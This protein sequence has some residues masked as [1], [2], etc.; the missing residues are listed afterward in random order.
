MF[1][2]TDIA[3]SVGSPL[4]V[5][6]QLVGGFFLNTKSIAKGLVW[7]QYLSWFQY[8]FDLLVVN[9]WHGATHLDCIKNNGGNDDPLA[10]SFCFRNG[11][12]VLKFV[13]FGNRDDWIDFVGILMLILFMRGFGF[14]ALYLR[15]RH[16]R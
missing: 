16:S 2:N 14:L 8:G 6:I 7:L 13:N 12:Q 11:A 3:L 1:T 9:Q 10:K 5:P 15:A 4:L